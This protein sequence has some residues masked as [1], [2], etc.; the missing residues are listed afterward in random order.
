MIPFTPPVYMIGTWLFITTTTYQV[1]LT[2][3]CSSNP[4]QSVVPCDTCYPVNNHRYD[5]QLNWRHHLCDRHSRSK[6]KTE[7]LDQS[8]QIKK[9][10]SC[11]DLMQNEMILMSSANYKIKWKQ[12]NAII[13]H[14]PQLSS[15]VTGQPKCSKLAVPVMTS[16][17][18]AYI[19]H[20][21]KRHNT[22]LFWLKYCY[23][24]CL[25]GNLVKQLYCR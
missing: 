22:I 15:L 9:L 3:G 8:L 7:K 20:S 13:Q 23:N 10:F 4:A 18:I 12:L 2:V 24:R 16:K 5:I 11:L 25:T 1:I 14:H 17:T 6:Q 19:T 21:S